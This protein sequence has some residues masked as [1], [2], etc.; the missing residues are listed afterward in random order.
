VPVSDQLEILKVS[1]IVRPNTTQF[2]RRGRTS[3]VGSNL[4]QAT[5][6][7]LSQKSATQTPVNNVSVN[8]RKQI[9]HTEQE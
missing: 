4:D 5:L 8:Q 6:H 9:K 3:Q 7:M 2:N 1:E